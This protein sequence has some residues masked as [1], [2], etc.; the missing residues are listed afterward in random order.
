M[1]QTIIGSLLLLFTVGLLMRYRPK[2]FFSW[3][4][5]LLCAAMGVM[6]I[7]VGGGA[8]VVQLIQTTAQVVTAVCALYCL[9]REKLFAVRRAKAIHTKVAGAKAAKA[10]RKGKELTEFGMER[11]A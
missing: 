6:S 5:C 7:A 11:C 9:H 8:W 4:L 2:T 3:Y 1:L 10:A